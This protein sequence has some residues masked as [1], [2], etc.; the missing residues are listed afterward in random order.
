MYSNLFFSG[1]SSGDEINCLFAKNEEHI[2]TPAAG[3]DTPLPSNRE[4]LLLEMTTTLLRTPCDDR[5]INQIV[6]TISIALID[7]HNES[8]GGTREKFQNNNNKS[9]RGIKDLAYTF[10]DLTFNLE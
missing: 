2:R 5:H 10:S 9:G 8:Y 4:N 6:E 3:V 7:V 1:L